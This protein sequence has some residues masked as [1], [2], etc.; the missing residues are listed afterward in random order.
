MYNSEGEFRFQI[1]CSENK[2]GLFRE[3]ETKF[4]QGDYRLSDGRSLHL[5]AY[6]YS[7]EEVIRTALGR[8]FPLICLDSTI[9]IYDIETRWAGRHPDSG[10]AIAKSFTFAVSPI[11]FLISP[12]IAESIN[13]HTHQ[14]GWHTLHMLSNYPHLRL[15]HAHGHTDDGKLIAIAEFMAGVGKD[16]E[17]SCIDDSVLSFVQS[18]EKATHEYGSADCDVI[19]RALGE[20]KW[21]ADI[22]IAQERNALRVLSELPN[23]RA[24]LIYPGEGTIWA[25][26]PLALMSCWASQEQHEA[27]DYL[28]RYLSSRETESTLLKSGLHSIYSERLGG[29]YEVQRFYQAQAD[30]VPN[31]QPITYGAPPMTLPGINIVRTIKQKWSLAEKSADV[32]LVIDISGSM[33]ELSKLPMVKTAIKDLLDRIKSSQSRISIVTFNGSANRSITLM[34]P[35]GNR[36][37]IDSIISKLSAGGQTA[38]FD[39]IL[40]AIWELDHLGD[41]SHIQAILALTDGGENNSEATKDDVIKALANRDMLFYGIAYGQDAD[42][43][44][45]KQIADVADGLAIDSTPACIGQVFQH[46]ATHV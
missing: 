18:L 4:N 26:H 37:K 32:C 46:L 20:G 2:E 23:I 13:P 33:N 31:I 42:R 9:Q 28:S 7:P 21:R 41:P 12:S 11:I 27:F 22:I 35:L 3:I 6:F 10:Q 24:I 14:I 16:K 43:N 36:I 44:I 34:S 29:A 8:D 15:T 19:T 39:A 25:D 45:L 40:M 38:L 5:Q 30:T 1:A 17:H